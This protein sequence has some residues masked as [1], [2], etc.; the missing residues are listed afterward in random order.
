MISQQLFFG[1]QALPTW[2][3]KYFHDK[4]RIIFDYFST[5]VTRSPHLKAEE[6]RTAHVER[7]RAAKN[8][9]ELCRINGYVPEE[10]VVRTTDGYLLGIHR[11][12]G[13]K[14]QGRTQPGIRDGKSVV[15]LH[16]GLL[17]NSEVWVCLTDEQRCLP[18]VLAEKGY[19]VWVRRRNF[20]TWHHLTPF[21]G[22]WATIE[23]TNTPK[24]PCTI[25]Q[26]LTSSGTFRCTLSS[27]PL[28]SADAANAAAWLLIGHVARESV[29][30][31]TC[32]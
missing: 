11:L 29:A 30:V 21:D 10:H 8:F 25:L 9:E 19:D 27:A 28:T 13:K 4:S 7:I 20:E 15:Y 23:G 1:T 17:M 32:A 12:P 31:M 3:I 5:A 16:H 22:S 18:F 6:G 2:A 26:I 24:N 14:N